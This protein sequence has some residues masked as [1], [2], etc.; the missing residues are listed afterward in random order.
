MKNATAWPKPKASG[1]GPVTQADREVLDPAA[2]KA[3]LAASAATQLAG[4][5]DIAVR[6]VTAEVRPAVQT[7]ASEIDLLSQELC[8]KRDQLNALLGKGGAR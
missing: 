5:M 8:R 7:L 6:R 1:P 4:D 2:R 3:G